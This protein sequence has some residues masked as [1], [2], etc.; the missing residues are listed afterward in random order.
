MNKLPF[1]L[2][3]TM[4][5]FCAIAQDA[6]EKSLTRAQQDSVVKKATSTGQN[7]YVNPSLKTTPRQSASADQY[8]CDSTCLSMGGN[9]TYQMTYIENQTVRC[10]ADYKSPSGY[11]H[12]ITATRKITK[13]YEGNTL[14]STIVGAWEKTD[15]NTLCSKYETGQDSCWDGSY[16][17][18]DRTNYYNGDYIY[19][20]WRTI[21]ACPPPPP[22][23]SG[24]GTPQGSNWHCDVTSAKQIITA[25]GQKSIQYTYGFF[26]NKGDY[27]GPANY[28]T[29]VDPYFVNQTTGYTNAYHNYI[30]T[31]ENLYGN[32]APPKPLDW[33]PPPGY[34][35]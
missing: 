24:C 18:R 20:S 29:Q 26:D 32:N 11:N 9:K 35:F 21:R 3:A 30:E 12:L 14:L 17:T 6:K 16:S 5:P 2:I 4:L 31:G 15:N 22:V 27:Y 13:K 8:D 25:D 33:T 28:T 7:Q 10:P 1:V 19:S 23:S 34:P